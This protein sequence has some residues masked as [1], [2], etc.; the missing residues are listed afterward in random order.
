[1]TLEQAVALALERSP[2]LV[3][4]QADVAR[5]Q[6][7]A[8]GDSRF[9]QSNPELSAA[10]GP[11]LRE[12]N[13][14]LELGLG[15]S[16][17]VEIFGQPSARKGA[18]RAFV[19]ASEARLRARRVELVAEV[20]TAFARARAAAQE[21]RLAEDAR[22]LAAEAL[23]A[24]VERLEAGAA[25]RLEV[26]TAR[27][28]SG[29]AAREYNRAI[30]RHAAALSELSLLIGLDETAEPQ[31]QEARLPDNSP[32]L[33]LPV[34]LEQALRARAD[35]QAA[36]AE[37]EAS[38]AQQRLSQR[39]ALPSPRLG[40]TYSREE[41]AHIIQGTLAIDLPAFNRNQAARGSTAA[42]VTE[43]TRTLEAVERMAR[44]EVKL[45]LV[46]YQTAEDSLRIFG[47]DAQKALQE[48]LALATEGYRA[49]K[50]DFLE[51]LVIRRETLE[52]RRDHIEA[53]EEFDTAQAQ[54]QRVI[55]SLP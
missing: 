18:A 39:E 24:A 41:D 10:V 49:G 25:S 50:M 30:R 52:A 37:L 46:R 42:Q 8:Q 38:Q 28:E 43:A 9:F 22:T 12:G 23:T 53:L 3:S 1:M 27:V 14:S 55:G 2:V 35:I 20:R 34:L 15:L 29:R 54:L 13:N 21:V 11:R 44:A 6:A 5:A 16:Q 7:Q 47:E 26:N 31:F 51:L 4:L 45:A 36:R 19:S 17:R 48:N 32:A 40:A 33:S